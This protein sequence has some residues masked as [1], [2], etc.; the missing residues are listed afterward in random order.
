MFQLIQRQIISGEM[1][2]AV[3]QHRSMTG[4]KNKAISVNPLRIFR[5]ELQVFRPKGVSHSGSAHRHAG[6]SGIG[7]LNAVG[8]KEADGVDA[9][10]F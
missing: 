8:R 10:V 3:Q 6:M 4:G 5:I 2:Q 9:E 7:I 1:Q